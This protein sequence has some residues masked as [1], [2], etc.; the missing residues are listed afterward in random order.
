MIE[1]SV[2]AGSKYSCHELSSQLCIKFVRPNYGSLLIQNEYYTN[3]ML[4]FLNVP[5]NA[6]II[7]Q[8]QSTVETQQNL[9]AELRNIQQKK[10]RK[11]QACK[12]QHSS[13]PFVWTFRN[14]WILSLFCLLPPEFSPHL[15][16]LRNYVRE[17]GVAGQ[18]S[19]FVTVC[20]ETPSTSTQKKK[21]LWGWKKWNVF[22]FTLM[23]ARA[24]LSLS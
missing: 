5:Y 2:Q 22:T 12:K 18:A 11:V 1:S 6:M 10:R 20:L 9:D 3:C 8:S 13:T 24:P 7:K 14:L 16:L 23:L 4:L 21:N 17:V 15:H 19:S